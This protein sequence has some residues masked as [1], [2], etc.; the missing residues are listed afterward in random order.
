MVNVESPTP[1]SH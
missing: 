1:P